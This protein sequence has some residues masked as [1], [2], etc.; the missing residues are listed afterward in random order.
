M[1]EPV[2]T[3]RHS[4]KSLTG[5]I[6]GSILLGALLLAAGVLTTAWPVALL[7][8]LPALAVF[9]WGW[10]HR[11]G[12]S[13]RVYPDRLEMEQGM[14]SRRIENVELFR[15]RDVGMK[16]G[17]LG[18]ML[19]FGEVYVHST[20]ASA[21]DIVVS[22]IDHPREFYQTLRDLVTESRAHRQTMI[23]EEGRALP[24]GEA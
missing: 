1:A 4:W 7:S 2:L 22:A 23:V 14:L 16:Q 13:Y 9:G 21:P 15:V 5:P 8:P 6:A 24:P 20:D 17:F 11:A 10:V 19:G 3:R 18:R 12:S